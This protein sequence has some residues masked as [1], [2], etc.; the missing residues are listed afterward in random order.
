M[1]HLTDFVKGLE[2][3]ELQKLLGIVCR[4]IPE[5]RSTVL[6]GLDEVRLAKEPMQAPRGVTCL[7]SPPLMRPA[8]TSGG[9]DQG[10]RNAVVCT[11]LPPRGVW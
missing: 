9:V 11:R 3:D 4:A 8:Y 1:S 5:A 10:I 7:I 2:K 6:N